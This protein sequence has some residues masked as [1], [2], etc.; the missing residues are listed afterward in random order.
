[1][2]RVWRHWSV[3]AL[4]LFVGGAL[5]PA[6]GQTP[7]PQ[8]AR[9]A[10]AGAALYAR[11]C[12]ACHGADG[13]GAPGVLDGLDIRLPDFSDCAFATPEPDGDWLAVAHA[14]GPARAFDRRMPAFGE[15]LSPAELQLAIA[16]IRTLCTNPAWPRGELNLPRPL[17]TEKAFPEN[18]AVLTVAVSTSEASS[19]DQELVYERRIGPRS[20][21]EVS[22]P[23]EL[24]RGAGGSW[25][26]GVGDI[27]VGLKHAWWHSLPSG[28]IVSVAGEVIVPSGNAARGFGRGVTVFEPFVALGQLLPHDGFLQ[29]QAGVELPTDRARADAEAFWRTVLGWSVSQ[30]HFGRTW[31]PMVE[32]LA[33]RELVRGQA[34]VWDIVPQL[35]VTLSRRQHVMA[36]AG[37]RLPLNA[38]EGRP[39]RVLVYVL[40]DWFD[41][42]LFEGW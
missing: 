34:P 15:A 24:A 21:V 22:V 4:G 17:V 37:I 11:A 35:Q 27:T 25:H 28:R 6:F 10:N 31:T 1:M 18:E 42:G 20:Q 12:A 39:T 41:G 23:L 40:W 3:A 38:R 8:S 26:G 7:A 14:G 30:A 13:R 16:H 36:N 32:V 19:V 5:E 33:A 29:A 2:G 9:A